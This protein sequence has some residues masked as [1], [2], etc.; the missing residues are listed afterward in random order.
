MVQV[1]LNSPYDRIYV[2][3]A[4]LDR[5]SDSDNSDEY[6]E[7]SPQSGLIAGFIGREKKSQKQMTT[8]KRSFHIYAPVA[9]LDRVFASDA[10]G[11][12]FEPHQAYQSPCFLSENRGFFF[13]I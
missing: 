3:V 9:Q 10:K 6:F 7:L 11:R 8:A 1:E 5:V 2:A 12:A 13:S 4:Q